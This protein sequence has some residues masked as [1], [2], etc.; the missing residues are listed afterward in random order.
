[1]ERDVYVCDWHSKQTF[2]VVVRCRVRLCLLELLV[3]TTHFISNLVR[4][5]NVRVGRHTRYHHLMNKVHVY[6]Y[7]TGVRSGM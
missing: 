5:A 7:R 1:M 3:Y 2:A 4:L 6:F